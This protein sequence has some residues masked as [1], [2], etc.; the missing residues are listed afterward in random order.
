[1][2]MCSSLV[3]LVVVLCLTGFASADLTINAPFGVTVD[4]LYVSLYE[5]GTVLGQNVESEDIIKIDVPSGNLTMYFDGSAEFGSDEDIDALCINPSEGRV[6]FS[7]ASS[8][9][10]DHLTGQ[11]DLSF[12]SGDIV[13]YNPSTDKAGM[14]FDASAYGCS[15]L[16]ID[17]LSLVDGGFLFSPTGDF[18]KNGT[19]YR[20]EDVIKFSN[21]TFSMIFDGSTH[22]IQD[23]AGYWNG[24]YYVSR[25][26]YNHDA[27]ALLC[28]GDYVISLDKGYSF[29]SFYA[30]D[31]DLVLYSIATGTWSLF[32]DAGEQLDLHCTEYNDINGLC[33]CSRCFEEHEDPEVPEPTSCILFGASILGGLS[34]WRR[35]RAA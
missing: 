18:S 1:M 22:G 21:G 12:E 9:K 4:C 29:G 19:T 5:D 34:I 20:N 35:R 28:N 8:A 25:T 2:R 23:V 24:Y 30:N 10:F 14:Y 31:E 6:Y 3:S 32:F 13:W 11:S 27:F 15:G 16:N 33:I 17:S 26:D 7:T